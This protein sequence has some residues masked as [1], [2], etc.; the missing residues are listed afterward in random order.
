MC[1]FFSVCVRDGKGGNLL[2]ACL[3]QGGGEPLKT[4][5]QTVTGGGAG[6]LDVLLGG[7]MV[8]GWFGGGGGE[9]A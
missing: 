8:S 7:R 9:V 4:L 3:A 2:V 1:G 5:V 6:G